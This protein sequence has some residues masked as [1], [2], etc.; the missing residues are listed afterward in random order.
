M[1]NRPTIHHNQESQ[2]LS[3]HHLLCRNQAKFISSDGQCDGLAANREAEP[4][5]ERVFGRNAPDAF[6]AQKLQGDDDRFT[7]KIG[8][9]P[10]LARADFF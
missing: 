6:V 8:R 2:V 3:P 4:R 10:E 1:E 9:V 7:D 5:S